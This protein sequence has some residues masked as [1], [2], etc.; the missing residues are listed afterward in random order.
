M[1]TLDFNIKPVSKESCVVRA[2]SS[3]GIHGAL[4]DN[5]Q[6]YKTLKYMI[7]QLQPGAKPTVVHGCGK[8]N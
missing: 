4:G 6:N 8:G 2:F 5:S 7:D 3:S 1:D